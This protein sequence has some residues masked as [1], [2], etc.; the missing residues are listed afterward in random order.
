MARLGGSRSALASL[1]PI[2]AQSAAAWEAEIS[3]ALAAND[4]DRLRR[5]AHQAKGALATLAAPQAVEF[6]KAL[7][8]LARAGDLAAAPA[9][10]TAL[11]EETARA[12]AAVAALLQQ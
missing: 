8:D 3:A 2:I 11:K 1:A 7:E 6:A 12:Q 10:I 4:A 5:A 9:A